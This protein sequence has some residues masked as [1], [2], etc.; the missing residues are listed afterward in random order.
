M[1]TNVISERFPTRHTFAEFARRV[2]ID[3][4][5]ANLARWRQLLW[6]E[7][8]EAEKLRREGLDEQIISSWRLN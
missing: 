4:D 7:S 2:A 5:T 1:A 6:A 8:R 3:I